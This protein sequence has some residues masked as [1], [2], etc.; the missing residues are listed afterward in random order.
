MYIQNCGFQFKIA[1]DMDV[2]WYENDKIIQ[3]LSNNQ[4]NFL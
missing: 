3:A 2:I 4:A 1:F